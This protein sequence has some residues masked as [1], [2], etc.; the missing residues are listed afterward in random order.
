MAHFPGK[1]RH[2]ATGFFILL[3]LLAFLTAG[4]IFSVQ[5]GAE[6]VGKADPRA[7]QKDPGRL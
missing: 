1:A 5:A 6:Q 7:A 3:T 4:G 2:L